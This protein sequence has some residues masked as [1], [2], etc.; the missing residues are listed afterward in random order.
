MPEPPKRPLG[1]EGIESLYQDCRT[2]VWN[3]RAG[4]AD[5]LP[6]IV[7]VGPRGS[8]KTSTLT[9]LGYLGSHRPHAYYDFGSAAPRRPHE[10]AGR[11]AYGLS[12]RIPRQPALLFPRLTL[13]LVVVDPTLSLDENDSKRARNQLR[14]ALH[15][16]REPHAVGDHFAGVTGL[17]QDLNVLRI[18]GAGLLASLI[19]QPPRVPLSVSRRTGLNWY[20][21]PLS[22]LDELIALNQLAKSPAAAD[23]TAVDRRLCKAFLADLRGEYARSGRDRNSV[24]LLDNIDAESGR[25]FLD[26]L[27]ELRE[28]AEESDPLLVVAGA[29]DVGGIP[30]LFAHGPAGV[31]I[32]PPE[33]AGYADWRA[34]VPQPPPDGSWRWYCV[35][36]RDLTGGEVAQLGAR[37]TEQLPEA[38][39][40]IHGLTHGHPWGVDRLLGVATTLVGRDD[41]DILLR[42]IVS[43]PPASATGSLAVPAADDEIRRFLL[44]DLT[45]DQHAA[46]VACCAPR[47]FDSAFDAGLLDLF[48]T[49]TRNTV[50]RVMGTRLWLV[51]PT[52]EDAGARGGRGSGYLERAHPRPLPS[53]PVLHPWLRLLLLQELARTPGQWDTVHE[54]LRT[55]QVSHGH[56]L[57]A[58]YHALALHR[59]DD[60][61]DHLARGLVNLSDTDAWLYELY[62]ITAAP[63]RVPVIP[64]QSAALRADR[65]AA[66]LAP[67]SFLAHRALTILVTALW[68]AGDP[69]NRL[70]GARPELAFTISST[71]QSLALYS[72]P[73]R[74]G[75]RHEA[76]KY[77]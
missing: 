73:P 64:G 60:V 51:D 19:R 8:G 31:R 37:I 21:G 30:G 39:A 71:L 26:L 11:L 5:P 38:P 28:A 75:L 12:Y 32:Q 68:L 56:P 57:E 14:Q 18:P 20:A 4:H 35:R 16:P 44:T 53:R 15:G 74:V 63:L 59:I 46:M 69:R 1:I 62:T 25:E 33:R 77:A 70:P 23:Q 41:A 7:L 54:Q 34:A 52:P 10:V 9:W 45:D 36:L 22:P 2:R 42:G 29:S 43:D 76:A 47:A 66:D 3:G 72:D 61:V 50:D 24:V 55:W 6:V 65:L 58:Q 17:L 27:V 40:L 49:H 48:D 67:R 13:G